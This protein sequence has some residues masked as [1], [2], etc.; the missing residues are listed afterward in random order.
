MGKRILFTTLGK[1]PHIQGIFKAG[2]IARESGYD[3]S[4]LPPGTPEENILREIQIY[5]PTHIGFSYR[6]T[7]ENGLDF[8]TSIMRKLSSNAL[9]SRLNG[10]KRKISFA[11]LPKTVEMVANSDLG[12]KY[13]VYGV[14]QDKNPIRSVERLLDYLDIYD[15]RRK[16]IL[17]SSRQRLIP[18]RIDLLDQLAVEVIE[19]ERKEDPLEKPSAEAINSYISRILEVWSERPLLRVHYGEPGLTINPTIKGIRQ[20]AN[21]GVVD[22][23]SLGSSDFSQRYF[24]RPEKWV[25]KN[26]GGVP[27]RNFDDLM[28]L[29]EATR[30]GNY[31]SIRTYA[32]VVNLVGYAIGCIKRDIIGPSHHAVPLYY[33]NELDGRGPTPVQE[34]IEEHN[35]TVQI[36]GE[37]GIATEMNDPNQWQS[38]WAPDST[39]VAD[40]GLITSIMLANGV[41]DMVL[42]MQFNKPRETSDYGD[43]AKFTAALKLVDILT[44]PQMKDRIRILRQTRTGIGYF[45]PDIGMADYQL[46]RSTILQSMIEPHAV[47]IVP[48]CEALYAAKPDDIIKSSDLVR[49]AYSMYRKHRDDLRSY[50]TYPK[51]IERRDELVDEALFLLREIAKLNPEY[52]SCGYADEELWRYLHDARTLYRALEEGYMSAPGIFTEPYRTMS[53]DIYTDMIPGGFLDMVDPNTFQTISQEDRLNTLKPTHNR[54]IG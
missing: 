37:Y 31:P 54:L 25:G 28:E 21:E 40:Y 29:L 26:D 36:L 3:V 10:E 9:L 45:E 18:P 1:D 11:G 53:R 8:Y 43:L 16:G 24:D 22:E 48:S 47:H 6:L 20:L 12:R 15:N 27:Y 39:I 41:K 38:R 19:E 33:F 23:I 46:A 42:Q 50:L 13:D 32:H 51:V 52:P 7:P 30:R 49:K 14:Q 2:R 44:S 5:D 35:N 17:E 4:I 34:S